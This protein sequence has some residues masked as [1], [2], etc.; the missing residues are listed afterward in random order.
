MSVSIAAG[1]SFLAANKSEPPA[2]RSRPRRIRDSSIRITRPK[3]PFRNGLRFSSTWA[4][5]GLRAR[6]RER[7]SVGISKDTKDDRRKTR[8]PAPFHFL[9]QLPGAI[10]AHVMASHIGRA[11]QELVPRHC[12]QQASGGTERFGGLAENGFVL[13]DVLQDIG[14][15]LEGMTALG[16]KLH[17]VSSVIPRSSWPGSDGQRAAFSVF[18]RA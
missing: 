14:S 7:N 9:S 2:G 4:D 8:K 6:R 10:A 18:F 5:S 16:T 3:N 1:Y 13:G 12:D 15:R 11:P 17:L